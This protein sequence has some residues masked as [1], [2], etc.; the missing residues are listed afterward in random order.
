MSPALPTLA[1]QQDNPYI[2]CDG[3]TSVAESVDGHEPLQQLGGVVVPSDPQDELAGL[4]NIIEQKGTALQ[5]Q[6]MQ[7]LA[8]SVAGRQM[9][10][11]LDALATLSTDRQM[12]ARSTPEMQET[13]L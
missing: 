4:L 6:L 9:T 1:T 13:P 2:G 3:K 7:R 5:L 8:G 10:R 12:P 11:S